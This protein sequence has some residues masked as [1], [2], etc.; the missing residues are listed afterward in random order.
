MKLVTSTEEKDV[1]HLIKAAYEDTAELIDK[2]SKCKS[3]NSQ[4]L[5]NQATICLHLKWL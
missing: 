1:I 3:F 2:H 5:Q 4:D